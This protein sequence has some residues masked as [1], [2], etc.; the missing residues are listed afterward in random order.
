MSNAVDFD[1][2][3]I[4]S[5]F[6]NMIKDRWNYNI[7]IDVVPGLYRS[8]FN[9]I[10]T[11]LKYQRSKNNPHIGFKLLNEA[12]EFVFGA[13]LDYHAPEGDSDDTG[14]WTLSFTFNEEDMTDLNAVYDNHSDMFFTVANHEIRSSMYGNFQTELAATNVYV[15]LVETIA[16]QLDAI[17]N[18]PENGEV[19][20]TMPGIF[21]AGVG[22]EDGQK[23]FYIIPGH[24]IKQQIKDDKGL[25]KDLPKAA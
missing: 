8:M 18:D 14:N 24:N 5:M 15:A 9:A 17:S 7:S 11:L 3:A 10:A 23:V 16:K 22:F 25:S 19:E 6:V 2:T 21:M 13:I 12:G 4:P 1:K 20:I